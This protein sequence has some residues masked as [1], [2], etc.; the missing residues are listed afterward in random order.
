MSGG[1]GGGGR[2]KCQLHLSNPLLTP[3]PPTGDLTALEVI[4]DAEADPSNPRHGRIEW[5]VRDRWGDT[6]AAEADAHNHS[7]AAAF[8][9]EQEARVERA[10]AGLVR[11]P[12]AALPDA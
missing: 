3:P 10:R 9:R 8:L 12:S 4:R 2:Q 11:G 5:G 1:G 6:P 7:V